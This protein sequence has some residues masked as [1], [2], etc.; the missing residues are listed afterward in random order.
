M[1][2]G[3]VWLRSLFHMEQDAAAASLT[4]SLIVVTTWLQNFPL[5]QSCCVDVRLGQDAVP[6]AQVLPHAKAIFG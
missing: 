3:Y 2:I 5:L 4:Y 6:S 1:I